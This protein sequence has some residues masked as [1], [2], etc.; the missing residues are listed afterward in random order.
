MV[1]DALLNDDMIIESDFL[2]EVDIQ[3]RDGKIINVTKITEKVNELIFVNK[4]DV[5]SK[6]NEVDLSYISNQDHRKQLQQIVSDYKPQKTKVIGIEL[7]IVVK[8]DVPIY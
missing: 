7:Q 6:V 2:N 1:P 8:D 3:I 4:I 5:V